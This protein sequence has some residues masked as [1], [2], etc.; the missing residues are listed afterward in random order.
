[1]SS[2]QIMHFILIGSIDKCDVH[3]IYIEDRTAI[4]IISPWL[5]V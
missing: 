2:R 4:D 5:L 3:V 1:M